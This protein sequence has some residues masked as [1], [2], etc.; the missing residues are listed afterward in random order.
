[1]RLSQENYIIMECISSVPYSLYL[2]ALCMK[3]LTNQGLKQ[4]DPLSPYL[5]ILGTEVFFQLLI[6]VE[7][8]GE[9]HGASIVSK[10]PSISHLFFADDSFIL[11]KV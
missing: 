4:G 2:M 5:F 6:K 1:M 3:S 7:K 9:I 8:D 10:G 11:C